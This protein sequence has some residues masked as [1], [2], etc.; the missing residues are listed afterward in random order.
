MY[1]NQVSRDSHKT[2][3]ITNQDK[4]KLSSRSFFLCIFPMIVLGR[5]SKKWTPPLSLI[6][7]STLSENVIQD[8]L[9]LKKSAADWK[10]LNISKKVIIPFLISYSYILIQEEL[11]MNNYI[12]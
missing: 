6:L 5:T 10:C 4:L 1:F 12:I 2:Q 9:Q 7:S 11:Q 8:E 3:C